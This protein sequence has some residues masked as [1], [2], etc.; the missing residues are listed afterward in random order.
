MDRLRVY[1]ATN[2]DMRDWVEM[3]IRQPLEV[4]GCEIVSTWHAGP[5]AV[6]SALTEEEADRIRAINLR[7][8]ARAEV[9]VVFSTDRGGEHHAEAA[10]AHR[11]GLR[12]IWHGRHILLAK[13]PGVIRCAEVTDVFDAVGDLARIKRGRVPTYPPPAMTGTD[14]R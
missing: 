3:M 4:R 2:Y 12:L 1:I 9:C 8:L 11:E 14:E 13:V 10:L 5:A 6:E 7:D